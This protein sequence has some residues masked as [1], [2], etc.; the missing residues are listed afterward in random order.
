MKR[1]TR[2]LIAGA[3]M[4]GLMTGVAARTYAT[5]SVDLSKNTKV[6][7][8]GQLDDEG[9]KGKHDCKGKNE[10]KGT[11]GCKSGDNGCK[12]KNSCKGHGGC[13]T[14]KPAE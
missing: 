9:D 8:W 1:T 3:A 12:G 5:Q 7:S 13:N 4:A 14:N 6:S 2:V 11:G 10:C